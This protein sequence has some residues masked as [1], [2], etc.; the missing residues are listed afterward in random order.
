MQVR[1]GLADR[2]TDDLCGGKNRGV[3]DLLRAST[4]ETT[5]RSIACRM[6]FG[7]AQCTSIRP[8]PSG[9][10]STL[11]RNVRSARSWF[12]RWLRDARASVAAS[13][14]AQA[15]A[16]G[17]TGSASRWSGSTT[18]ILSRAADKMLRVAAVSKAP[19]VAT[20]V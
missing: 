5:A 7:H 14:D 16:K 19:A 20:D 8:W 10:V 3:E 12:Q 2:G 9:S 15:A 11:A 13:T 17:L 6:S 4:N 1:V 18:T